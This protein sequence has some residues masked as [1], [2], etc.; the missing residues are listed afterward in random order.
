MIPRLRFGMTKEMKK[1][2]HLI[3]GVQFGAGAEHMLLKTLPF[4]K[5]AEQAVCVLKGKGEIGARLEERGV[6]VFYLEMRGYFDFGVIKRYKEVVKNF[7]PD[8]QVNYLIHAD[9]FGRI[10]AKRFGVKKIVSYIRNRHT[11]LFFKILDFLTLSSVDYLLTNSSAVLDFYH[12]TYRF[13]KSRSSFIPNGI[14][15]APSAEFDR[16]KLKAEIGVDEDDFTVVSTSRLHPQKDLPTLLRALAIVKEKGFI[17]PKL[18]LCGIGPE[19]EK[20]EEL[21]QGLGLEE[22]VKFLGVRKD[23]PDLL[24]I[25][26]VFVLPS[27]HEGMSNSLLE[28]MKEGRPVIVS[29]IPENAEL[30]KDKE[31]GLA[32]A[33]G[34]EIALAE[35]IM[36]IA[37]SPLVAE[38][39]AESAKNTMA[40]YDILK[41]IK[42]LDD[43]LEER[44]NEKTKIIWVANDRNQIYLNFFK[45]LGE[46]HPD[47]DLFLLAGD[48]EAS[49]GVEKFYRWQVFPFAYRW[50]FKLLFIPVKLSAKI[51]G[52]KIDVPNLDYYRGL[53]I[54]LKKE[55]PD[56]IMINLYM[57]PT[58]WQT[59][60]Y[61][62]IHRK[63]YILLEEKKYL[64][65]TRIRKV[66]SFFQL[67]LAAPLFLLAKKIYCYTSDG[68]SFGKK[69]F[70]VFNKGKIELLPASVDTR[71]F[72]NEHFDKDDC[73][74]KILVVARMV[75]YKRYEDI[76][77]AIKFLKEKDR[78]DFVLNIRGDGPLEGDVNLLIDQLGVRDCIKF[79]PPTPYEDLRKVYNQNDILVLASFNEAIGIVVPE[80]M[81]C[82][83][84][85]VI[86]DTCG[87]KTYVKNGVNS[88]IFKTFDYFD[89]AEKITML[90]YDDRR[91]EMAAAA[92]KAIKEEFDSRLIADLFFEKIKSLL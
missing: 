28:A 57:Q 34:N 77:R 91:A 21:V 25:A 69:H 85:V 84:P 66:L 12:R 65:R 5:M 68:L 80:A 43:F 16:E 48:N 61:C 4:L 86:S 38:K 2:L 56:L 8:L 88:L 82:G 45:A 26:G 37:A 9:V 24:R 29:A 62:L 90:A 18:L 7:Q 1:V 50:I 72:Y 42:Q 55:N 79:I 46:H 49:S 40:N 32:F 60:F 67:I 75:P 36:A 51:T 78:F 64:G 19:K 15:L 10:F 74:L 31:N 81:A 59:L 63:P 23:I 53:H 30:V 35:K 54:L 27:R 17:R 13:P 58:S 33:P 44:L 92:E 71:L 52:K 22:N 14:D 70:P 76:L 47:L 73:R 11:R 87:S 89:L 41:I 39:L 3:T 83:L 6:K 20:L